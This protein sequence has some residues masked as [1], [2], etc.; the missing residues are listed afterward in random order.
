MVKHAVHTQKKHPL[1]LSTTTG[2]G[3]ALKKM[4]KTGAAATKGALDAFVVPMQRYV[5]PPSLPPVPE[6]PQPKKVASKPPTPSSS[7]SSSTTAK[8]MLRFSAPPPPQKPQ[9]PKAA[10]AAAAA[11]KPPTPTPNT[12]TAALS[13]DWLV[14]RLHGG[15]GRAD[16]QAL[17]DARRTEKLT[18]T[19]VALFNKRRMLGQQAKARRPGWRVQGDKRV[20]V[21]YTGVGM[22]VAEGAEAFKLSMVFGKGKTKGEGG[23]GG[24]GEG[25]GKGSGGKSKKKGKSEKEN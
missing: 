8:T 14:E 12:A 15:H 10:A 3:A 20:F 4:G 16:A 24:G 11:T 5:A 1:A 6:K 2:I 25:A 17:W 9:K 13:T 7:S 19:D 22:Q 18:A 21:A 23:K